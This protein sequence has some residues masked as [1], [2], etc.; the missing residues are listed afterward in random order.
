LNKQDLT[1]ACRPDALEHCVRIVDRTA[2][3]ALARGEFVR[4]GSPELA[5]PPGGEEMQAM[6][7][8]LVYTQYALNQVVDACPEQ[9]LI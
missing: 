5:P 7:K 1:G 3:G 4:H 2:G 9:T 8:K 6:A